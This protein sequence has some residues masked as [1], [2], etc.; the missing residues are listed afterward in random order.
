MEIVQNFT[1]PDF[2]AKNFTP[3]ISPN[4]NSFSGKK[5]KKWVKME[6]FTPLAKILHC[7]RQWREWQIPPLPDSYSDDHPCFQ[8]RLG[9]VGPN[10]YIWGDLFQDLDWSKDFIKTVWFYVNLKATLQLPCSVHLCRVFLPLPTY[11]LLWSSSTFSRSTPTLGL[12][13]SYNYLQ[14]SF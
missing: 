9:R 1:P 6:K 2:Q 5:H 13:R 7:R 12:C 10:P 14:L 3:S 11:F 4:L 8:G